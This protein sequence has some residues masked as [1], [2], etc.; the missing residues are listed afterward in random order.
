MQ[1]LLVL[2][3]TCMMLGGGRTEA[4]E[5]L[6]VPTGQVVLTISGNIEQANAPGQAR[7]DMA[8]LEA[9][10]TDS[11]TTRS[12]WADHAQH[13]E[14]VLLRAVLERV[15]AKGT[16]INASA[17]ND[18][19]ILIPFD[20]LQYDPLI[21]MRVDGEALKIR[22]KGPLWIVY[23]RDKHAVLRDIRYDSRWVWQLYRLHVE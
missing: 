19:K 3:I 4:A 11:I 7:F 8:M 1:Y 6:P 2:V 20:D 10:G 14:G 5:P 9:I 22:D 12:E 23:P 13:F 21:A 16:A 18:Y 17:L 15:G